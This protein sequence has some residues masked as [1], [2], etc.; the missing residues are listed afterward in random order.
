MFIR[1]FRD[2]TIWQ[3]SH[4]FVLN[5]YSLTKKFPSYE[6]FGL[7][8]QI[9]RSASSVPTNIVEGYKKTTR[10]FLKYL[11]IAEGSLEET[12][13]HLILSRDLNYCSQEDFDQL[14]LLA[15][16]IGIMLNSLIKKLSGKM[17]E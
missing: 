15:N 9:R 12:K 5:I 8:N 10:E 13:Y 16:E 6:Q 1:S 11:C 4:Q 3:K 7:I 17:V 14:L 2:L